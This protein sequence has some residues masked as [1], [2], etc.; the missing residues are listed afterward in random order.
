MFTVAAILEALPA[1]TTLVGTI[2]H[3]AQS[4]HE[5]ASETD[6]VKI[7][8]Q[9]ADLRAANDAAFTALDA[10]LAAAARR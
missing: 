5:A 2:T 3:A 1:L 7:E 8:A 9:L 4:V 6:Q 10:K